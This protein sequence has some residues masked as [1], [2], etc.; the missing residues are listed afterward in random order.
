MV[1]FLLKNGADPNKKDEENR[2]PLTEANKTNNKEIIKIL[3]DA[4]AKL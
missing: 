4:G 1:R 3:L 2:N